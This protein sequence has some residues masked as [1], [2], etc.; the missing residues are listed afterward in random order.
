MVSRVNSRIPVVF[1]VEL[2]DY[3]CVHGFCVFRGLMGMRLLWY[4]DAGSC[5]NLCV[6]SDGRDAE[7]LTLH[8]FFCCDASSS[9]VYLYASDFIVQRVRDV[10]I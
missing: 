2:C 10:I 9:K 4:A 8:H 3:C 5:W 6:D 1:V 7:T